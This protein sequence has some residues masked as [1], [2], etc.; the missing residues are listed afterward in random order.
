M[1]DGFASPRKEIGAALRS[2]MWKSPAG[3]VALEWPGGGLL[4][5][6]RRPGVKGRPLVHQCLLCGCDQCA[7]KQFGEIAVSFVSHPIDRLRGT[8]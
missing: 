2:P 8:L 5:S 6:P 1:S 3:A 7:Q 4:S